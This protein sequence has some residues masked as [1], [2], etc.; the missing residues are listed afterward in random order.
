VRGKMIRTI[1]EV[2][3]DLRKTRRWVR[4]L[5]VEIFDTLGRMDYAKKQK[6]KLRRELYRL[7]KE[8]KK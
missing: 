8:I 7:E 2:K 1:Q 4:R 3:D 6:N 5:N